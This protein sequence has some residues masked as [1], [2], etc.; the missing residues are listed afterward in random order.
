MR[1]LQRIGRWKGASRALPRAVASAGLL[2][3][4]DPMLAADLPLKAP[5]LQS[6]YHWTGLYVGGHF[7]YGQGSLGPDSL[8]LPLQGLIFPHSPTGLIGGYA[9]G[10]N[11][12]LA[13]HIVLGIEADATFTTYVD[14]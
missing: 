7:G 2:A 13:N 11:R 4:A 12:E 8:Q 9:M 5:A 6:V 10:Y 14:P 3:L 1:T